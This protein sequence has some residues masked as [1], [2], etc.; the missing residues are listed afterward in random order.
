MFEL[1]EDV[2]RET[3]AAVED[4]AAGLEQWLGVL[5]F[6]PR[7]PTPLQKELMR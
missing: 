5:R 7:F 2:G 6:T 3:A 4:A 1:L